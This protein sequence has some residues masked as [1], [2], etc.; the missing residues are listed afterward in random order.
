M[1]ELERS[2]LA[3]LKEGGFPPSRHFR[4]LVCQLIRGGV[5]AECLAQVQRMIADPRYVI[6]EDAPGRQGLLD[7]G[8]YIARSRKNAANRAKK[9]RAQQPPVPYRQLSGKDV[10]PAHK[11]PDH[12]AQI[13]PRLLS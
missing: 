5:Q 3:M 4:F 11:G 13:D 6:P 9:A 2:I 12:P 1:S 10:R 8:E 7:L